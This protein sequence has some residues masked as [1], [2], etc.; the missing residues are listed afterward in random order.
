MKRFIAFSMLVNL[1]MP[2]SASEASETLSRGIYSETRNDDRAPISVSD[3]IGN[4][5]KIEATHNSNGALQVVIDFWKIPTSNFTTRIR[6]CAPD[7]YE[8]YDE[9]GICSNQN[10]N[11]LNNLLFFSPSKESTGSQYGI[12]KSFKGVSK[13][14]KSPNQWVYTITGTAL[15]S[16][17]IGLVEVLMLY[18]SATF[19]ERTTTCRGG[20][21]ITCNTRSSNVFERDAAEVVMEQLETSNS[22]SGYSR[23]FLTIQD[24]FN[25]VSGTYFNSTRQFNVAC[26]NDARK[27]GIIE[28][29][30][31]YLAIFSSTEGA[32]VGQ[33]WFPNQINS[34]YAN[35]IKTWTNNG[36]HLYI[37]LPFSS[38]DENR[39]PCGLTVRNVPRL[40]EIG[41][42]VN[43]A[44]FLVAGPTGYAVAS[45]PLT[46]IE[47]GN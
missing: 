46:K 15:K 38:P 1:L 40:S 14:G 6:W 33:Q 31:V 24:Y 4:I 11:Y 3:S 42:D 45:K 43:T 47:L 20:Y 26:I 36:S 18:S 30:K 22:P 16:S 7:E 28:G 19:T 17:S 13:K 10:S 5:R 23:Q 12:R 25:R 39:N 44:L 35:K 9:M 29:L 27:D 41:L 32:Y 34:A 8:D 21:T 37:E 2:V